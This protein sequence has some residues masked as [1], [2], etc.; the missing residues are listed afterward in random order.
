MSRRVLVTGGA[1][2]LGRAVA[3]AFH[4]Q[5]DRVA[6]VGRRG[7]TATE[8]G[9]H[10]YE[11]WHAGDVTLENLRSIGGPFDVVVH[12]A[13]NS[14]VAH[15]LA[16]PLDAFRMTVDTLAET[17]EYVRLNSPEARVLY[18]SSAAVYG[19]TEDAPLVE[20]RAPNP[21]A[22]YGDQKVIAEHLLHS[23]ALHAGTRVA[24]ARY[25]SIYGPG[26]ARQLLWDASKRFTS[27]AK[28]I[29]FSG[30]GQETR[31]WIH[32]DDAATLLLALSR[33]DARYTVVNGAAGERVTV[34]AVL[35]LLREAL[36]AEGALRFNQVTR[37]GDPR[38]YHADMGA[39]RATGFQNRVSLAQGL[40]G[41]AQWF[42][43]QCVG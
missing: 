35:G 31:D 5:G 34:E 15:S 42:R 29:E 16:A 6:G 30:T 22:P 33:S 14:S 36:G 25:F 17:L 2:F 32:V 18:P 19:A 23:A 41:Y 37:A 7:W 24:V 28:E 11:A 39:A 13:G 27:G 21:V 43:T 1:G 8:A 20:S 26:L 4:A 38:F 10:G 3:R 9:V 40:A 12:C